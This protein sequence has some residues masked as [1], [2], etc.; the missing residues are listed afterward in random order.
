MPETWYDFIASLWKVN[1]GIKC[2]HNHYL[3]KEQLWNYFSS[4]EFQETSDAFSSLTPVESVMIIS[5]QRSIVAMFCCNV[6]LSPFDWAVFVLF[7]IQSTDVTFSVI[8]RKVQWSH[9]ICNWS[10]VHTRANAEVVEGRERVQ[11]FKGVTRPTKSTQLNWFQ[12]VTINNTVMD[13]IFL[14][15][16]CLV[17]SLLLYFFTGI[18]CCL[19]KPQ[20]YYS[21]SQS[22]VVWLV[23]MY[24]LIV[25]VCVCG[26]VPCMRWQ[27]N[28]TERTFY[29][30]LV[31]NAAN[32]LLRVRDFDCVHSLSAQSLWLWHSVS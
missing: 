1:S 31:M 26:Y 27:L 11:R 28:V 22:V 19:D 13:I 24:R 15:R 10:K 3:T 18:V 32:S 12:T 25:M 30:W 21:V 17:L 20:T 14:Y 6:C 5:H 29:C 9:L 2:K 4:N 8:W 7:E 16:Y 23:Y